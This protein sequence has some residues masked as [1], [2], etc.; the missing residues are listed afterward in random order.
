MLFPPQ[1]AGVVSFNR[2]AASSTLRSRISFSAQSQLMPSLSHTSYSHTHGSF[3]YER[4][5]YD[6]NTRRLPH[7]AHTVEADPYDSVGSDA[8]RCDLHSY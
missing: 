4:S 6:G 7:R 2:D 5:I 8:M 3:R 1:I